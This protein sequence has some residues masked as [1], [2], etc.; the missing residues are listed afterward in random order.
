[1]W[2]AMVFSACTRCRMVRILRKIEFLDLY[3]AIIRESKKIGESVNG[4]PIYQV[5]L[6]ILCESDR[7]WRPD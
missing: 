3:V 1:M 4:D 2:C 6:S 7:S 5:Q